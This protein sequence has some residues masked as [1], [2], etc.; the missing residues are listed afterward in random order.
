M[1]VPIGVD[2]GM[3]EFCK[4]YNLRISAMPFDWAVSY[5]GVSKCIEDD[6]KLFSNPL[7][8]RINQYDV[9]FHHDFKND[10]SILSDTEKYDRRCERLLHLL[11]TSDE[12]I[13]FCRKGHACHHHNEHNGKYNTIISDIEDA[14]KLNDVLIKKYPKLK[15]KIIVILV[16]DKCFE[17]T[18]TYKSNSELVEVYNIATPQS[19]TAIFEKC[20]RDIFKV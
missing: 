3:V 12:D 6:L 15:Y 4:K 8:N 17:P 14:E 10:E 11:N 19:D 9:Y 1:I 7:E 5:N 13:T 2:C 18:T 16:C 20:A